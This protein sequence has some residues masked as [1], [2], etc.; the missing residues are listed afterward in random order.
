MRLFTLVSM[1]VSAV[2]TCIESWSQA[3]AT[4]GSEKNRYLHYEIIQNIV[5]NLYTARLLSRVDPIAL[6]DHAHFFDTGNRR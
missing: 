6:H 2:L 4:S 5:Q 1:I 3:S